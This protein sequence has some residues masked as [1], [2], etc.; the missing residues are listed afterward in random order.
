VTFLQ[1]TPYQ[2]LGVLDGAMKIPGSGGPEG[3]GM[4]AGGPGAPAEDYMTPPPQFQRRG[5]PPG[6][7]QVRQ[8]GARR[9][10]RWLVAVEGDSPLKI[11]VSSQKGGTRSETVKVQ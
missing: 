5:G 8:G 4:R 10:V 9:E 11:V 2:R 6:P 7:T 1:G 3:G